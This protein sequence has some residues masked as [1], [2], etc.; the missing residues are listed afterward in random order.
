MNPIKSQP[1]IPNDPSLFCHHCGHNIPR[2]EAFVDDG[3]V[4]CHDCYYGHYHRCTECG[5]LVHEAHR[6]YIDDEVCCF[7]CYNKH[8][9]EERSLHEYSYKPEPIFYGD[10]RRFLGVELEIDDAGRSEDNAESILN[11]ANRSAKH[12]YIKC[13]SSLDDGMELVTHPMTLDYHLNHAPWQDIMDT[14]LDMGY[15]SH[16]TD[17]CGLHV[18]VNRDS[19]GQSAS[20]QDDVIGR[21][22]FFVERFWSELLQFSRR[23]SYQLQ[24]WAARYGRK[25]SPKDILDH[26]KSDSPGRYTC[27]NLQNR[28][29]IEFRIFRG[30]L[31]YNTLAATL[32]LVDEICNVAALLSDEEMLG[33]NWSDFVERLD[34]NRHSE[35]LGY[36]S[37]RG[38]ADGNES[39]GLSCAV[40]SE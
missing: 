9:E 40:C 16:N 18:H 36:L 12:M 7:Y 31:K 4:L 1:S 25:G 21:I 17:T 28:N 14:C 8:W 30:T 22:L 19:F 3:I 26:A 37:L 6:Y 15:A 39:E 13:D 24:R 33:L 20:E 38:L 29:T 27:V 34:S 23:T 2:S 11:V 32:Q 10:G 5:R 35:L